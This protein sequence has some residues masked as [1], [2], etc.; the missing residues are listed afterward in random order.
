MPTELHG[1][2][3]QT[4]DYLYGPRLWLAEEALILGPTSWAIMIK[5]NFFLY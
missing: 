4:A 2:F 1:S 3:P 5:S